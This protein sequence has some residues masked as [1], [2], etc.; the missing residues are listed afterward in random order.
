M[1]K[2]DLFAT[3]YYLNE[4]LLKYNKLNIEII[5]VQHLL[6]DTLLFVNHLRECG[7][8]INR[9]IGIEYSSKKRIVNKLKING[10]KVISPSFDDL[11]RTI[12]E[13]QSELLT[14]NSNKKFIILDVGGYFAKSILKAQRKNI[15][16]IIEDTKQG[17]WEYEKISNKIK[18]PIL[19][20]ANNN[21]KKIEAQFVAKSILKSIYIN[22]INL[23]LDIK[24]MSI[25][26][27]GFGDIG[28]SI[29]KILLKN[30][31]KYSV[32]DSSA[33]KEI[34]AKLM[35]FNFVSREKLL[36]KSNLI[37]G[38]TG[39]ESILLKDINSM[40]NK[41]ILVSG[42]SKN[43]EF[44]TNLVNKVSIKTKL[45]NKNTKLYF[46]KNRKSIIILNSG[47][48]INF[49]NNSSLPLPISDLI[50]LQLT[51]CIKKILVEKLPFGIGGLSSKEEEMISKIWKKH[52]FN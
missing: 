15:A 11:Q 37:I 36:S 33:V 44:Q 12:D 35:G 45:I 14:K 28:L 9:V 5:I 7:F 22:L 16:G 29:C 39:A 52:H 41:T 26:V 20:I 17:L 31:V 24:K 13:I 27:I 40:K 23:N 30:K 8:Y 6:S 18:F 48:P 51:H 38:V 42:S 4:I 34:H 25:G 3:K 1:N 32:Y 49:L 21:L 19:E 47:Y 10:I 2:K 50:F 46:L 43:I